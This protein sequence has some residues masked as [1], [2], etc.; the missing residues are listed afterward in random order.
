VQEREGH[1]LPDDG[2]GLEEPLVLGRQ[3]V[4]ARRQ[5]RLRRRRISRVAGVLV[6]R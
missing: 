2:R 4:D 1:I 3:P 5:D 6:K